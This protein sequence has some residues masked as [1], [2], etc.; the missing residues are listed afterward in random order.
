MFWTDL[1][2]DMVLS[3]HV[4]I[5]GSQNILFLVVCDLCLQIHLFDIDIPGKITFMESKTL[6]AGETPTIVDTGFILVLP[7]IFVIC[8]FY[9]LIILVSKKIIDNK[10]WGTL[11]SIMVKLFFFHIEK[12]LF[13]SPLTF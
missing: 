8:I 7:N 9:K 12:N 3:E 10:I 5:V 13:P 6:T 1:L 11:G 4:Y 2:G